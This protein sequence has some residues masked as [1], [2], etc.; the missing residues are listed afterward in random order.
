VFRLRLLQKDWRN[1]NGTKLERAHI[2]A[3]S[4]GGK[5]EPGNLLLLCPLC[6]AQAPM[7][8]ISEIMLNWTREHDSYLDCVF[9]KLDESIQRAAIRDDDMASFD[10]L[11]QDC[12]GNYIK[13]RKLDFH[14]IA[15]RLDAASYDGVA[16]LLEDYLAVRRIFKVRTLCVAGASWAEIVKRTGLGLESCK[17]YY[18][19]L[20]VQV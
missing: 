1:W 5:I 20:Q 2:I 16:A 14:P 15:R 13:H 8:D 18:S 4:I 10:A 19:A 12:F 7:T 6:H 11:D 17:R 9:R 3:A